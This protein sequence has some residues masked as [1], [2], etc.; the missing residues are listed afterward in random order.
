LI[1]LIEILKQSNAGQ[2]IKTSGEIAA[3]KE[4]KKTKENIAG[5]KRKGLSRARGQLELGETHC[6]LRGGANEIKKPTTKLCSNY[7]VDIRIEDLQEIRIHTCL[8]KNK[9]T[10]CQSANRKNSQEGITEIGREQA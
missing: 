9:I 1:K 5:C 10:Q 2:E 7:R 8:R 3:G 6:G 4:L